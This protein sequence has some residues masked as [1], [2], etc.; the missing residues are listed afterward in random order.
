M[1][2]DSETEV[3]TVDLSVEEDLQKRERAE[4]FARIY[5]Q[6]SS[7]LLATAKLEPD[8]LVKNA[9]PTKSVTYIVGKPG[10]K[11]SWLGYDLAVA[12]IQGRS[13]MGF[14]DPTPTSHSPSALIL[15]FDNPGE[16][17]ARRFL[18]LGLRPDDRAWFHSL[19]AHKPPQGY[20]RMLYLPDG[21]EPLEAIIDAYRPDVVMVDSLRQCHTKDESSSQE[22]AEIVS[23]LRQLANFGASVIVIHHTRKDDGE[24]RGSTEIEA[25]AD[26]IIHVVGDVATWKKTRGW[27]MSDGS[28]TFKLEDEGDR[29]YLKGGIRLSDVLAGGPMTRQQI[30]EV[31][32]L[33]PA[34]ITTVI[35]QAIE[36]GCVRETWDV[37]GVGKKVIEWTANM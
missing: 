28:V 3:E 29:T 32:G 17:C 8:W 21:F 30:G 13:W 24:M 6:S 18:R 1:T 31:M 2:N 20:P 33:S 25:S 10:S 15:N 11:K 9:I 36:R 26:A 19:G 16:E 5:L 7:E 34:A 22:M 4:S 14:G 35:N 27:E 12:T 37:T 23:Y